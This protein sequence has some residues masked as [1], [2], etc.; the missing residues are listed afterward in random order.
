MIL[1]A[2]IVSSVKKSQGLEI[3]RMLKIAFVSNYYNHHQSDFSDAMASMDDVEYY[4]IENSPI[5]SERMNMG[6]GFSDKPNYVL[7]AYQSEEIR[8]RC[9]EIINDSDLVIIGS[10]P[11][12][13]IS[14]RHKMHK[15]VFRYSERFYKKGCP[16]WQVPLR[17]AKN[18]MRFNRHKNDYLLCASAF[19]AA[20]AAMTKSFMGKAYKWGYFPPVKEH[21][22]DSLFARKRANGIVSILWVGRLIGW[23]HPEVSI[24]L[25]EMLKSENYHFSLNIIGSGDLEESLKGLIDEKKLS[26]CVHLL[27]VKKPEEVRDYM[28]QSDIFL[29]TSDFNEGWG[30][31]LNESMNSGCSVVA[32]HAIGSVPFLIRHLENGVVY[33]NGDF[34]ELYEAVRLLITDKELR[35][36]L[37]KAAYETIV[38]EWNAKTAAE[39]LITLYKNLVKEGNC[40]TFNDGPCSQ[41]SIIK[42]EWF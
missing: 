7:S 26:D 21:N 2:E 32:S 12:E 37:G 24:L 20:D 17:Y 31:V 23:K 42:N 34:K 41:A 10:A 40:N 8:N 25:A 3:N 1:K 11:D 9:L 14:T 29:F 18:Y 4:F 13:I 36:N 33:H 28:E 39:R 15:I 35:E 22:L 16:K 19:T 5:T 38:N 6:W 30:A 27:G